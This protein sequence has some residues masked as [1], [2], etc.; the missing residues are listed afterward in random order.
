MEIRVPQKRARESAESTV[1]TENP[2]WSSVSSTLG[3]TV[4]WHTKGTTA[5]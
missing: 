1:D 5:F 3:S 4:L 2:A